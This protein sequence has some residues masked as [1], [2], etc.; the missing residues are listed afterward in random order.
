MATA[1]FE[2]TNSNGLKFLPILLLALIAFALLAITYTS[3]AV[4]RHGVT[5][6]SAI[7][8]CMRRDGP[9][10]TWRSTRTPN[11]FYHICE[12]PDGRFGLQVVVDEIAECIEKTC[13]VKGNGSWKEVTSY[14]RKFATRFKGQAPY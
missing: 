12:L 2:R 9:Y 10:Q 3:H 8:S 7:R 6:V 14:L 5:E 11:T 1:T 4:E 13:F